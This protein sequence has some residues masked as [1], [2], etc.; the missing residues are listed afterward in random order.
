VTFT[1]LFPSP[2][3]ELTTVEFPAV[4][5]SPLTVAMLPTAELVLEV[6]PVEL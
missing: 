6:E 3:R 5:L 1:A 4:L 2:V